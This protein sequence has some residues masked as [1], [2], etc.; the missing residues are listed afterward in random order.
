MLE[1]VS[2]EYEQI[3]EVVCGLEVGKL[4]IFDYRNI[5][6]PRRIIPSL[7]ELR[8]S[9]GAIKKT[10]GRIQS[11]QWREYIIRTRKRDNF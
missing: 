6:L 3:M 7:R 8:I 11:E 4:E 10:D 9:T 2:R 1:Q 5:Q